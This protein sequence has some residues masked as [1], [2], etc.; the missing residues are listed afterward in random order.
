L[1]GYCKHQRPLFGRVLSLLRQEVVP[2]LQQGALSGAAEWVSNEELFS[3]HPGCVDML[4]DVLCDRGF[5]AHYVR[6]MMPVPVMFDA[7]S[8][9]IQTKLQALH[10]FK[11]Q[12][13][14]SGVR[15]ANAL[16]ALEIAAR[17]TEAARNGTAAGAANTLAGGMAGSSSGGIRPQ[18]T[19][20]PITESFIPEHLDLEAKMRAQDNSLRLKRVALAQQLQQHA[21][22]VKCSSAG[23]CSG[24]AAAGDV[25]EDVFT[26]HCC[27]RPDIS[28]GHAQELEVVSA[29]G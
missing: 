10:R 4:L 23:G 13:D 17:I 19:A 6:E 16:K 21:C 18:A 24:A 22:E 27:L 9:Q 28:C 1:E 14:A 3:K 5:Q 2:L 20:S 8:G 12:F 29:S 11:F 15:D 7:A 26:I 25:D